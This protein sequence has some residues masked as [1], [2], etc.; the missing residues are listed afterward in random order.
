LPSTANYTI[1]NGTLFIEGLTPANYILQAYNNN[2]TIRT[3]LVTVMDGSFTNL[4]MFFSSLNNE[5]KYFY[6]KNTA[7][8]PISGATL[9]MTKLVGSSYMTVGQQ[10]SDSAGY[11][12]FN[13][14]NGQTYRLVITATG[15][16]T[17]Q[18]DIN[19]ITGITSYTVVM[20]TNT[21]VMFDSLFSEVTYSYLPTNSTLSADSNQSF[22]LT[23]NSPNSLVEWFGVFYSATNYTNVTGT[24][25]GGTAFLYLNT[26]S[27]D[28]VKITFFIKVQTFDL[29]SFDKYFLIW[30]APTHNT[31]L[32]DAK[33]DLLAVMGSS[34]RRINVSAFFIAVFTLIMS[35]VFRV[36]TADGSKSLNAIPIVL[37]IVFFTSI[38]AI[39]LFLAI[40]IGFLNLLGAIPER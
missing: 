13:L 7:N 32:Y 33:S 5:D 12:F 6:L 4:S 37:G 27:M 28:S 35:F 31:T 23:V 3:Y 9:S 25:A 30:E 11:S 38:G 29:F 39:P 21:T 14:D 18:F 1:T 19:T 15:Y 26:S 17:K 40:P 10:T 20:L 24:P 36:N 22:S 2:Y 16:D 34:S 8:V